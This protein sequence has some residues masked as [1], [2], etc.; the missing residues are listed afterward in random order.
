M[1]RTAPTRFLALALV[2]P[3]LLAA[4]ALPAAAQRKPWSGASIVRDPEWQKSFLGSY[5]FL[6]GAEPDIKPSELETLKEVIE[7]MKSSPRTAATV[8]EGRAGEGSSAALDFI[9]ANLHFQNGKTDR[10]V[11]SYELALKKFPD[12]RRA[13]KNL[14]LLMVQLNEYDG[15]IEQLTRAIELGERDGRAYGL[16]GYC[17]INK[18]NPL[19]AEAAYRNAILQQPDSKDWQLGLARALNTL[20]KFEESAALFSAFLEKYP[21]DAQAWKL[22]ANAY[23]GLDQPLAAAVNLEA[24]RMLGKADASTLK[25]LGD[26]YMNEGISDLAKE[27]YLE[28]IANDAKGAR[29]ETAYRAADLLHRAQ[30]NADAAEMIDRIGQ[31]YAKKLSTDEELQLLTLDAKVERARGNKKTA[32]ELLESIVERDGTRGDALLELAAYHR[33]QGND[34]RALLLLDRAQKLEKY[35]Y[36]ALVERAQFQVTAREYEQAA[37][38]LRQALRIKREPRIERYLARIED[39]TRR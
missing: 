3:L 27:A 18:E 15:A 34:Q 4:F 32:A 19:A 20:G 13:R 33:D 36:Q 35:E 24:V 2:V 9:L 5:G 12:F 11:E 21:E 10:A 26:I 31:R 16:L 28:V 25:L 38:L 29:F 1:S 6:S 30:A 8:L 23:L 14:G 37:S 17:Y 39:A 7:L 22:Q